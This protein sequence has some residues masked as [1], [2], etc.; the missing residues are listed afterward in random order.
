MRG[1]VTSNP[2]IPFIKQEKTLY[3]NICYPN[4]Q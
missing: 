3:L 1:P 4:M 2:F